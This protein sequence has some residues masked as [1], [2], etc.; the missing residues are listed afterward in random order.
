MKFKRTLAAV[1][2][3]AA[4]LSGVIVT[5]APAS[6][7]PPRCELEQ[8]PANVQGDPMNTAGAPAAAY[9]THNGN[10]WALRVTHPGSDKI[11]VT[12]RILASGRIYGVARATEFRD[13]V[14]VTRRS[15][16]VKFRLYNYGRIDGINFRTRCSKKITVQL[17]LNGAPMPADQVYI[18]ADQH[19]P[20]S[21]PFDIV[22]GT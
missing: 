11:V 10:G 2:V 9:L 8:W 5:D 18:G 6:A 21:V 13:N 19:H 17:F 15:K 12:G 20:G 1:T 3:G 16:S 4:L 7:R 22:R 14:K